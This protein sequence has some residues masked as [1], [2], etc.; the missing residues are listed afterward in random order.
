MLWWQDFR[1]HGYV[2]L[3]FAGDIDSQKS[4]IGYVF[5]LKNGP[6]SWV[7]RLQKVVTLSMTEAE[8]V[9]MIEACKKLIWLKDFMNE[10]DKE[11]VTSLYN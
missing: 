1:L 10:F 6:L 2:D 9:A 3:D 7:S 4:T 11:Q 8:Y 5:T